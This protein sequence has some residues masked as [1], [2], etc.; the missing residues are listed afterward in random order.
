M[1]ADPDSLDPTITLDPTIMV[2]ITNP[3]RTRSL[4]QIKQ[5]ERR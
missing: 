5:S 2:E 4:I 3:S 1:S